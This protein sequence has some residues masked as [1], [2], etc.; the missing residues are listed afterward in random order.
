MDFIIDLDNVT[1]VTK[2]TL[3][4]RQCVGFKI[5]RPGFESQRHVTFPFTEKE[6]NWL[7]IE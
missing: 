5:A 4:Q 6:Y 2:G 3:A 1:I 7:Q